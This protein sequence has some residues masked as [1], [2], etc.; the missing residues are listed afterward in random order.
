MKERT[1]SKS[2]ERVAE[3]Y[4]ETRGGEERG[5]RV[6]DELAPHLEPSRPVLEVGVGTGVVAFALTRRG[7]D[8]TGV[9][10]SGA[11]LRRAVERIGPRV[12]RADASR[13]PFA[14]RAFSQAYSV[15]V[16]HVVGDQAAVL[17]EVARVLAPGGRYLVAPARHRKR[18]D[19][20]IGGW[21]F[22]MDPELGVERRMDD[23]DA[24]RGPAERAGLR[25]AATIPMRP[26]TFQESPAETARQLE[27]RSASILWDLDDAAFER[28]VRPVIERLRAMPDAERPIT[29][30][31]ESPPLVMLEK[32][33]DG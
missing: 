19:D 4:D 14:D 12:G 10:I 15:W 13:L 28:A 27:A 1:P 11:M 33:N 17:R 5:E 32:P 29:R 31:V 8:M 26:A 9:D 6:A 22:D 25:V 3:I 18:P 21:L 2:F 7:F 16:L 24:L 20:E 23:A 30:P